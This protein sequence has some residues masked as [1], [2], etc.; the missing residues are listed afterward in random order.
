MQSGST[1]AK[2]ERRAHPRQRIQSLTYVELGNGNGGIA[3]NVSEGGMTV[4]AAQ[5]L[6]A[7]GTLDIAL[8]LPQTRKRLQVKGE[9]RWLSDS[10]KEAGFQ[11]IDLSSESL[12]DIR[13]R[14]IR[15]R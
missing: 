11:F 10:R 13:E 15:A 2:T 5:P 7:E 4:V 3:L 6:D 12:A 14:S 9:V 1:P 8:Q